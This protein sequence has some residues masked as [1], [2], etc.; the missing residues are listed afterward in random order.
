MGPG[1]RFLAAGLVHG[2]CRTLQ[3]LELDPEGPPTFQRLSSN[4]FIEPQGNCGPGW[5][6]DQPAPT[7]LHSQKPHRGLGKR[8]GERRGP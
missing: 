6:L 2:S 8:G 1:K 5:R 7:E 4:P 3:G